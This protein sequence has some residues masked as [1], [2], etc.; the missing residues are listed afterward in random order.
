LFDFLTFLFF[1]LLEIL[2]EL[3]VLI[4][5]ILIVVLRHALS[6]VSG[7]NGGSGG[8]LFDTCVSQMHLQLGD[9]CVFLSLRDWKVLNELAHAANFTLKIWCRLL[10]FI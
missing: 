6:W 8:L 9:L 1:E 4:N 5:Q 3:G 7:L 10:N 2:P